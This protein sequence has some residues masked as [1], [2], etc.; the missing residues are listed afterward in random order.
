MILGRT[1]R[2]ALL[3]AV[4]AAALI[5]CHPLINPNDPASAFYQG[6]P[7]RPPE[8]MVLPEVV[9]WWVYSE[10]GIGRFIGQ[11]IPEDGSLVETRQSFVVLVELAEPIDWELASYCSMYVYYN[12]VG[13]PDDQ[14][15]PPYTDF[16]T[17]MFTTSIFPYGGDR[18]IHYPSGFAD[19]WGTRGLMRLIG[20][21]GEVVSERRFS[22]LWGDIDADETVSATDEATVDS[23]RYAGVNASDPLTVRSD[24]ET[25]GF[26]DDSDVATMGG[27]V[28]ASLA[29]V[30]WPDP[31]L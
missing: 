29:L 24:V 28:G 21:S 30:E 17:N 26:I 31:G 4:V 22:W 23:L 16:M 8:P 19:P 5:S 9:D 15:N 7:D 14:T 6:D 25:N 20:P 3:A 18:Y 12:E 11:R 1:Q 10:H 27:L 13:S 2:A